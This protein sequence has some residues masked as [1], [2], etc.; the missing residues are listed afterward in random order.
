MPKESESHVVRPI[1]WRKENGRWKEYFGYP[2][3]E[4]DQDYKTLFVGGLA[5]EVG[6]ELLQDIFPD[7]KEIRIPRSRKDD[8]HRGV[9]FIQFESAAEV[10]SNLDEK[11]GT[12]VKGKPIFLDK[13]GGAGGNGSGLVD[14]G[15]RRPLETPDFQMGPSHVLHID[16]FYRTTKVGLGT[17]TSF[18]PPKKLALKGEVGLQPE[19]IGN[20]TYKSLDHIKFALE[21]MK[22]EILRLELGEDIP[23]SSKKDIEAWQKW[24]YEEL[25]ILKQKKEQLIKRLEEKGCYGW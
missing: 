22:G 12:R 1:C 14:S 8:R 17:V 5:S 23:N 7:S 4:Q 20:L 10:A 16:D 3:I 24:R 6:V 13:M 21:R 2:V 9:A 25:N 18:T 15:G 19:P 11:Q